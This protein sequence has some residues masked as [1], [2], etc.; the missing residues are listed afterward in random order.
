MYLL[1]ISN[2]RYF[3]PRSLWGERRCHQATLP[4]KERISIHAPRGGSD[5]H[6]LPRTVPPA[7]FN[8]RSPRGE[9]LHLKFVLHLLLDFNP[10]SPRGERLLPDTVSRT[11]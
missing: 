11:A 6:S 9:R 3:N 2:T 8:P 7:D 10:R 1:T 4:C 5:R